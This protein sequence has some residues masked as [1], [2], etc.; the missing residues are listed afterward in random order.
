[1][2]KAEGRKEAISYILEIK[3]KDLKTTATSVLQIHWP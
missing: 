2:T 3:R 1:M